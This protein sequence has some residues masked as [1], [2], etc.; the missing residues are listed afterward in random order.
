MCRRSTLRWPTCSIPAIGQGTRRPRLADRAAAAAGQFVRP[1][2]RFRQCASGAQVDARGF[3][4]AAAAGLYR[5]DA[6]GSPGELDPELAKALGY[7]RQRSDRPLTGDARRRRRDSATNFQPQREQRHRPMPQPMT[8]RQRGEPA[9]ARTFA[10][11]RPRRIPRSQ[12]DLDAAP[13]AAA[14]Q[15]RRRP[16][17]SSSSPISTP[18]A[19]SRRRSPTW[20]KACG[21]TT[22]PRCCSASPAPA[23]PSPWPR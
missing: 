16:H 5:Q 17:A 10:A 8:L 9:I 20:S 1:P 19:T 21:A 13:A 6:K 22:A 12:P 14:G 3:G 23:R 11:R 7:R 4:E 15:I 18:R 2:R